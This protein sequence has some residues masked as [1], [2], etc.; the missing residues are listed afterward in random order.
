MMHQSLIR[1][2][3]RDQLGATAVEFAVVAGAFF[4]LLFAVIEYGMIQFSKVAIE[5]ATVQVSRASSIG[6][7]GPG[8]SGLPTAQQRQCE[9]QRLVTEK[10]RGLVRPE[11]VYVT[12]TVISAPTT[13]TPA[14]PDMC[15]DDP[16][17]PY[18]PSAA[19]CTGAW[20]NNSGGPNYD[21]PDMTGGNAGV[22][23][24]IVE[25]RVT[26]LWRVLFPMFRSYFGNNGV[27]TISA[28]TVIKNEP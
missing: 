22:A 19:Q 14:R 7:I 13:N 4:M 1:R 16:T 28:A 10:T 23:G 26:Y 18:P 9:I 15:L 5:A 21:P 3:G 20:V 6:N 12:S 11:S 24:D 25:I 17:N 27:L 8:C 2:L